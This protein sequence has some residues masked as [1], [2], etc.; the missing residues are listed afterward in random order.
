MQNKPIRQR[1]L[2]QANFSSF[3]YKFQ[4]SLICL[5]GAI[6]ALFARTAEAQVYTLYSYHVQN[7]NCAD[8]SDVV[9]ITV[10]ISVDSSTADGAYQWR[11]DQM[12]QTPSSLDPYCDFEVHNGLITTYCDETHPNASSVSFPAQVQPG[13]GGGLRIYD[14]G[15]PSHKVELPYKEGGAIYEGANCPPPPGIVYTAAMRLDFGNS[16]QL[17]PDPNQT[18]LCDDNTGC[19]SCSSHGMATYSFHLML[20]SLHIEDTPVSY[21]PPRGPSID[22]KVVYNQRENPPDSF[23]YSNLG[24][25][26]TFNWL[27]YVTDDPLNPGADASVYVRGGGTEAFSGFN[28]DTQSYSADKQTLAV[29][30]RTSNSTYEKRFPDGSREVFS[31]SD[32]STSHPRHIFLSSVVDPIGNAATLSY[33]GSLRITAITDSLGQATTLSYDLASDPLNG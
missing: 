32:M 3:R 7:P 26:W 25:Q 5:V 15:D 29:L 22:F 27:S 20:A 31:V 33:D 6:V 17:P 18:K 9:N 1:V 11:W 12:D 16:Q 24:R 19:S 14:G 13:T 30:V 4:R 23:A 2:L 28:P 21:K 8:T 10:T